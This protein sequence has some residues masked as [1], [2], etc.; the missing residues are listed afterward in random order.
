L[1]GGMIAEGGRVEKKKKVRGPR[2]GRLL[3]EKRVRGARRP[4]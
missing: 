1:K 3:G 4:R 2:K